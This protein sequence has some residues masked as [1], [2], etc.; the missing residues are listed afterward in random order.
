METLQPQS[1]R[2]PRGFSHGTAAE[3]R[4]V[5]VAG[6]IGSNPESNAVETDDFAGQVAQALANTVAVLGEAG[7]TPEH[8]TRMTWFVT[9]MDA[10][11]AAQAG[12]G[13]A[14]LSTIGKH[15]PA[16]TLVQVLKLVE[17][18]ACVEIETT[19][20]IPK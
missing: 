11:Q 12:I 16:M 13:E 17:P 8:I 9:D 20:V 10:Y 7:A 14:Y 5:F 1:W 19:A 6:Q 18:R 2:R 15:F 3:G 4:L